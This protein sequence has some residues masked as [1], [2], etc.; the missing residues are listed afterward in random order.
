M[1]IWIL[2]LICI[3]DGKVNGQELI[4]GRVYIYE[5]AVKIPT[6]VSMSF[7]IIDNDSITKH[8]TYF[9]S[10]SYPKGKG[11]QK[12]ALSSEGKVKNVSFNEHDL[13]IVPCLYRRMK[14]ENILLENSK[15]LYYRDENFHNREIMIPDYFYKMIAPSFL[16]MTN[17]QKLEKLMELSTKE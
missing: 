15:E 9:V 4:N 8:V 13:K 2:I 10:F 7:I 12:S 14:D 11:I 16:K 5:S 17:K 3:L 1:K 6:R